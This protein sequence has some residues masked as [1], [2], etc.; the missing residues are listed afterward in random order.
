MAL[1]GSQLTDGQGQRTLRSDGTRVLVP[2]SVG[3]CKCCCYC[4]SAQTRRFQA[5]LRITITNFNIAGLQGVPLAYGG[6]TYTFDSIPLN[7][8]F[9]VPFYS[10]VFVSCI[11]RIKVPGAAAHANP[12]GGGTISTTDLELMIQTSYLGQVGV[13]A[14]F[15]GLPPIALNAN[16]LIGQAFYNVTGAFLPIPGITCG[17]TSSTVDATATTGGLSNNSTFQ[18]AA[19]GTVNANGKFT[20]SDV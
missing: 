8:T 11:Y 2:N 10:Q 5:S 19:G 20:I 15:A 17:G 14:L 13:Q 7:D 1:P 4:D 6:G 12:S 9:E 18:L 3:S 16:I